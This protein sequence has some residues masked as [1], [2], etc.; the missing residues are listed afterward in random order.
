VPV[1]LSSL[2]PNVGQTGRRS[3]PTVADPRHPTP[4]GC[5]P[6][7]GAASRRSGRRAHKPSA[8]GDECRPAG[9]IPK[10][11]NARPLPGA[12]SRAR[13]PCGG[14]GSQVCSAIESSCSRV[15]HAGVFDHLDAPR[16]HS[17]PSNSDR[18]PVAL[19]N[20]R[21]RAGCRSRHGTPALHC[22]VGA[23][24]WPRRLSTESPI[25][26]AQSARLRM[27]AS[28]RRRGGQVSESSRQSIIVLTWTGRSSLGPVDQRRSARE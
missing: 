8:R 21:F 28:V 27:G 5:C 1:G 23:G 19:R 15:E 3:A 18:F 7:S 2:E 9:R 17:V 12:V 11:H 25:L 20:R 13:R 22:V 4:S 6:C 10:P 16:T 26:R 24:R 14:V